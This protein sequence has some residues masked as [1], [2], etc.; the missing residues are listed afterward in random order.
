MIRVLLSLINTTQD[1]ILSSAAPLSLCK[2]FH[3]FFLPACWD[4]EFLTDTQR[5]WNHGAPKPG[6]LILPK[7]LSLESQLRNWNYGERAPG[8]LG[9]CVTAESCAWLWL[10]GP[11]RA[12]YGLFFLLFFA[13]CVVVFSSKWFSGSS[14]GTGCEFLRPC[15][16][17]KISLFPACRS[18]SDGL[19]AVLQHAKTAPKTMYPKTL[20]LLYSP[21][22]E[23]YLPVPCGRELESRAQETAIAGNGQKVEGLG[24][25]VV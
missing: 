11:I 5:S 18:A 19:D 16:A 20:T 23:P 21:Y 2:I 3:S 13:P 17:G 24:F 12:G 1:P 14:F 7:N 6:T 22:L 8:L 10:P 4:A 15:D 9:I 25:R